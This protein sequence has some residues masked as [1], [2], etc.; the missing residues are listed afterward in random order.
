MN[1]A[2]QK[3]GSNAYTNWSFFFNVETWELGYTGAEEVP[4]VATQTTIWAGHP[5]KQLCGTP[6]RDSPSQ[7]AHPALS[8]AL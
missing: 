4:D 2:L 6:L 3:T 1:V 8:A 7:I 5:A